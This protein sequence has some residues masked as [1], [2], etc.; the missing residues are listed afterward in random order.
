[1][2]ILS[3]WGRR[4]WAMFTNLFVSNNNCVLPAWAL[5]SFR[6][7]NMWCAAAS[8]FLRCRRSWSVSASLTVPGGWRER[9]WPQ[10][11]KTW[12]KFYSLRLFFQK[13]IVF[14]SHLTLLICPMS[15]LRSYVSW[16]LFMN[17]DISFGIDKTKKAEHYS[18]TGLFS[19]EIDTQPGF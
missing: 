4:Q 13:I 17:I 12:N 10:I 6:Q 16:W 1:M 2:L 3:S 7:N 15:Y 5:T 9:S 14:F 18:K 11:H 19:V 8:K